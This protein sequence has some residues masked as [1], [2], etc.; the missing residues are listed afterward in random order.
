MTIAETEIY[1]STENYFFIP[2]SM[3]L[4]MK[5]Q[6]SMRWMKLEKVQLC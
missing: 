3:P 2:G 1:V 5:N 6:H 4:N